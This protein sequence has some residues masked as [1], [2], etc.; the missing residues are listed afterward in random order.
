MY[1]PVSGEVVEINEDLKNETGKV[2]WCLRLL[3]CLHVAAAPCLRCVQRH[4]QQQRV[5]L[6]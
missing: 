6:A 1:A 3:H 2:R 5:V 4:V